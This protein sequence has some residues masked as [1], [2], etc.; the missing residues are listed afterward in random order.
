M[1]YDRIVLNFCEVSIKA[2]II[3]FIL[4][5]ININAKIYAQSVIHAY[6]FLKNPSKC[7][8]GY[9]QSCLFT[10]SNKQPQLLR[11]E[12]SCPRLSSFPQ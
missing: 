5:A 1:T 7:S 11:L 9:S 8:F 10:S 2:V 6:Q 3:L 4:A 12:Y